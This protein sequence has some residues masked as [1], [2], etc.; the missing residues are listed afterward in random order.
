MEAQSNTRILKGTCNLCGKIFK[1]AAMTNHLKSCRE[2][3]PPKA[4]GKEK[5]CK[6][7]VFYLLVEGRDLLD[8]WMH[9]EAPADS[10]L[11][12]LDDLLRRTWLECCNHISAFTIDKERYSVEP[13]AELEEKDMYI[14]LGDVLRPRMRFYHVYDYGTTTKLTLKVV[15]VRERLISNEPPQIL[16]RNEPPEIVCD[17]CGKLATHVC[18]CWHWGGEGWLCDACVTKHGCEYG[19]LLPVVNSPR[20]GICGYDGK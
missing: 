6:E 15:S 4:P 5:P 13:L 8:Y 17:S 19:M 12:Q 16:A 20:V 11:S 14:S 18:S 10:V 9:V 7:K 1:K 3:N 2:K